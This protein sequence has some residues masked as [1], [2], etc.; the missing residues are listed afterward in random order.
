M[1]GII[2]KQRIVVVFNI[3]IV[4]FTLL[5]LGIMLYK[6]GSEGGLLTSSSWENLKSWKNGAKVYRK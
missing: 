4:A 5:G 3:L 1:G 6:N 2:L